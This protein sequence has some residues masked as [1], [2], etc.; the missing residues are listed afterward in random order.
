MNPRTLVVAGAFATQFTVIGALFSLG[1]YVKVF[2]VEFGWS[3][4]MISGANALAFLMMG[5]LAVGMGRL[6]DRFGPRRV[7]IVTGILFG[8][9]LAALSQISAP[10]HFYAIMATFIAIGLGAHD[11]VTLS[12]IARWFD[13]RRGL[14][15]A[16]AKVGTAS[17]QMAFPLIVAVMIASIGWR[18]T[19]VYL[20][21]VAAVIL[22]FGAMLMRNPGPDD[23]AANLQAHAAAGMDFTQ[24]RKSRTLWML[25]IIQFSF[26]C[27]LMTMPMHLAAHG[28]DMGLSAA[29]AATLL[30]IVGGGSVAGR[31]VVGVL[32]DKIGCRNALSICLLLLVLALG[33]YTLAAGTIS[34]FAVTLLYGFTH[35]ALFVVISPTVAHFFGMKAHGQIF[36]TVLF[37]GTLGSAIGPIATGATFDILGSYSP[38]FI[39]LGGFAILALI[40]A[41]ALPKTSQIGA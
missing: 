27:T 26:F 9:G 37:F 13:K 33:G 32:V 34:L 5:I 15:T 40:L 8:I 28:M 10:W 24:A 17:G 11:V 4:T 6:S 30:S 19:F 36:G 3:R 18:E 39:V 22:I 2:E 23:V 31:L 25:C 29:K 1:L 16:V 21:V 20:G 35:G 12:T 41:R 38:A 14:M 7:L